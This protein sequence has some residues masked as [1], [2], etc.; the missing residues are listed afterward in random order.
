[1]LNTIACQENTSK[2]FRKCRIGQNYYGSRKRK[3]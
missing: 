2:K 1:M 3:V